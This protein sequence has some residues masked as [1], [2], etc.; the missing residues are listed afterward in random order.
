MATEGKGTSAGC[1]PHENPP[2]LVFP[3]S[4]PP[5]HRQPCSLLLARSRPRPRPGRKPSRGKLVCQLGRLRFSW[6]HA[7]RSMARHQHPH[8]TWTSEPSRTVRGLRGGVMAGATRFFRAMGSP[9]G[10]LLLLDGSAAKA[11][12]GPP[13]GRQSSKPSLSLSVSPE[14]NDLLST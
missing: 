11:L 10:Q 6:W 3:L 1:T 5:R 9:R 14:N 13:R 12:R 4:C 8:D 7:W 2:V